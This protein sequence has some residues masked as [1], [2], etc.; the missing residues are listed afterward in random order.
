VRQPF[1]AYAA[2]ILLHQLFKPLGRSAL[3]SAPLSAQMDCVP[4]VIDLGERLS[5][6]AFNFGGASISAGNSADVGSIDT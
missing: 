4:V 6:S 1:L 2:V 3:R 5:Q